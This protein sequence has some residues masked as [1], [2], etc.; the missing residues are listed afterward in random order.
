MR[1]TFLSVNPSDYNSSA[2]EA[3][4]ISEGTNQVKVTF[5]SGSTY[6][7]SNVE[8]SSIYSLT[9]GGCKSLGKWV[10]ECLVQGADYLQLA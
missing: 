7:Y 9:I 10:S 6:L 3:V 5:K 4:G 8:D 1:A 2:V